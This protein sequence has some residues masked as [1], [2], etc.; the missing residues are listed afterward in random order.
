MLPLHFVL[1]AL[2]SSASCTNVPKLDMLQPSTCIVVRAVAPDPTV[3]RG[4]ASFYA[5]KYE[6]RKTASGLVFHQRFNYAAH[7]TLPFGTICRVTRIDTGKSITVIIV[8][9]GPFDVGSVELGRPVPHSTRIIDISR[10][11]AQLLG[12]QR[13][14]VVKVKV[15]VVGFKKL[16]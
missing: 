6:N 15:E 11:S 2:V 9:R 10:C 3:Q 14:G 7:N 5:D 16:H 13:V 8:D 4:E 12:I 1:T